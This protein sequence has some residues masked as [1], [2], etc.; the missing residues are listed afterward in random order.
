[1]GLRC[2]PGDNHGYSWMPVTPPP[3]A[4]GQVAPP[5]LILVDGSYYLF[6]AYHALPPLHNREGLPTGAIYGVINM[7]RRLQADHQPA[8]MAVVFDPRGKT[9]RN[10]LDPDYKSNRPP[11]PEELSVQV[12]PLQE[13]I[14]AMGLPLLCVEGEE[15]DDVI[16]TLARRAEASGMQV[17]I[18][19]G[20]K[21][22]AQLVSP[23]IRLVDSMKNTVLDVAGVEQKFGVPPA[24][25]TDYLALIGDKVD[26]IPG[27][28]SVGPKT[29]LKWLQQFGSLEGVIAGADQVKGKVG[30]QLRGCLQQLPLSKQ[31]V[32]LRDGL[33]LPLGSESLEARPPDL[34]A[35]AQQCQRLGFNSWLK[36]L[37]EQAAA[38]VALPAAPDAPAPTPAARI[39]CSETGIT[40]WVSHLRAARGVRAVG[41]DGHPG[42]RVRRPCRHRLCHGGGHGVPAARTHHAGAGY[43]GCVND[44]PGAVAGGA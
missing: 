9:F 19:T 26:N 3:G 17:L 8:R 37:R 11:T 12:P 5:D 25:I 10:T 33:E 7:L 2:R 1:M 14:R 40:E 30:E 24:G 4:A 15:A 32:T 22:L 21:D 27:V 6:R 13:L 23:C 38:P 39:L 41:G 35:L 16:A 18:A 36:A 28:P 31:L 44:C 34:E 20:D 43:T 42:R 29:A